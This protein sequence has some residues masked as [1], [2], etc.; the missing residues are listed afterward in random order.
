MRK[1]KLQGGYLARVKPLKS[2]TQST[3]CE[4]EWTVI[5]VKTSLMAI[6]HTKPVSIIVKHGTKMPV[7]TSNKHKSVSA[8]STA[9][10][11]VNHL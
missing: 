4:Q 1:A 9:G 8:F 3:R 2:A 10:S 6:K 11:I 5:S 7:H